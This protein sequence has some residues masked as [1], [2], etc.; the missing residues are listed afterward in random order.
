LLHASAL[1]PAATMLSPEK[2]FFG[3]SVVYSPS[4]I[5]QEQ[6]SRL[7]F[8]RNA[9]HTDARQQIPPAGPVTGSD[10]RVTPRHF[11]SLREF[12]D[13]LRDLGDLRE[14]NFEV[15]TELEIGAIIR[16]VH[17]TYGPAP[18]FTNKPRTL[19]LCSRF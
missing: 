10:V 2:E 18:L 4:C 6:Q 12:L 9:P 13:T 15:D 11:T 16:R 19:Q 14:V 1:C 8:K 5:L 3:S 7:V 17:E